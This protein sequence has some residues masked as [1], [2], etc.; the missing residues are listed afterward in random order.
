MRVRR[1]IR[2]K[3]RRGIST[4]RQDAVDTGSHTEMPHTI[5]RYLLCEPPI[6]WK[7]KERSS[8]YSSEYSALENLAPSNFLRTSIYF[9]RSSNRLSSNVERS[10]VINNARMFIAVNG[11]T[12][13]FTA[14]RF[15][16]VKNVCRSFLTSNKI[17]CTI[18]EERANFYKT[19]FQWWMF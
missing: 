6:I 18:V 8:R 15:F 14:D 5:F 16:E 12:N 13:I 11:R 10:S 17:V 19:N 7:E 4:Y 9:A 3:N 2:R 1:K